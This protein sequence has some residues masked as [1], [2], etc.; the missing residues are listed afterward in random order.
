M[1]FGKVPLMGDPSLFVDAPR[2]HA[3]HVFSFVGWSE[4]ITRLAYPVQIEEGEGCVVPFR[5]PPNYPLPHAWGKFWFCI[6]PGTPS[7][8]V[9]GH[10]SRAKLTTGSS[11]RIHTHI[12]VGDGCLLATFCDTLRQRMDTHVCN[13]PLPT[14]EDPKRSL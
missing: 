12:I 8:I 2:P 3:S 5:E 13:W 1:C 9:G 7:K 6:L 4:R 10:E 11:I 14:G